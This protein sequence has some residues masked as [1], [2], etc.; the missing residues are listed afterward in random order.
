[1]LIGSKNILASADGINWS[2][3]DQQL[4]LF[5][6]AFGTE[7]FVILSS[8]A[9]QG[10]VL[11]STNGVNWSATPANVPVAGF[12]NMVY[13]RFGFTAVG[14][15]PTILTSTNA[16][17][18]RNRA[19]PTLSLSAVAYGSNS[20]VGV[21]NGGTIIQSGK[22]TDR[23]LIDPAIDEGFFRFSLSEGDGFYSLQSK[24]NLSEEKW[25]NIGVLT[26]SSVRIRG[27]YRQRNIFGQ[28][29]L[30]WLTEKSA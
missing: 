2:V 24:T 26:N 25:N 4:P 20:I 22:F 13:G 9:S 1:V 17:V 19:L 8:R 10:I 23:S 16:I 21:G 29:R 6:I 11:T 28:L 3:T 5:A 14:G 12:S 18:W 7:R 27:A 15:G 30:D